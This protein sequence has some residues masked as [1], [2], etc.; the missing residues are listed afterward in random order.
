MRRV[1]VGGRTIK[2][3]PADAIGK[4]G[5][6]DVYALPD[7]RAL[8]L[9]KLPD[10]PDFAGQPAQQDAA[11][12][13]LAEMQT[14][15]DRFPGT[16]PPEVVAPSELALDPRSREVVGYAMP[17]VPNAEVLMRYGERAF[18]DRTPV[19]AVAVLRVFQRIAAAVRALHDAGIVIG[20][21]NDLN[22]LVAGGEPRLID[23]DSMQFGRYLCRAYTERFLDPLLADRSAPR[24]ALLRPYEPSA[25]WYAFAAMLFRSLVLVDPFGGVYA[26]GDPSRRVPHPARPLRGISVFHADVRLPKAAHRLDMLPDAVLE[27]FRRVFEDADRAPFPLDQ[28]LS[29]RWLSCPHCGLEHARPA[30]PAC[31]TAPPA[32]ALP[33]TVVVRGEVTATR[34]LSLGGV[35]AAILAAAVDEAKVRWLALEHGVLRR[36]SGATVEVPAAA[37]GGTPWA[38]VEG[39]CTIFATRDSVYRVA[40][41]GAVESYSADPLAQGGATS[42]AATPTSLTWQDAG[43][44]LRRGSHGPEVV[45]SVLRGQTRIWAGERLGFGVSR[46]GPLSLAFLFSPRAR[47]INDRVA[48]PRAR[49]R[50][51]EEMVA[52][53]GDRVWHLLRE[54]AGGR[55]TTRCTAVSAAGEIIATA[56]AAEGDDSWLAGVRCVAAA[57]AWLFAVTEDGIVRVGAAAG[58]I[59]VAARYPDTAPFV[60]DPCQLLVGADGLYV[61]TSREIVRL[62]LGK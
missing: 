34:L 62:T 4:G 7:G 24:P 6:A 13:R 25:D 10:H 23:A 16:L 35:G 31:R 12:V 27:L 49:G 38:A 20:D 9:F 36:E 53:G 50:V 30:C 29:A 26:P 47:G 46:A 56:E 39:D 21:F 45:G 60:G 1:E 40:P 41:S 8:K 37:R 59:E 58:R 51:V 2:V 28:L 19:S 5:E 61:V 43:Q 22:V 57:G 33:P 15:L 18:R 48:L 44:L 54:S 11:R 14:K 42:V 55:L 32:P 52:I 3:D 17:H